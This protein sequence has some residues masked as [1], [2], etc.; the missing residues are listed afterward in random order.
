MMTK[1][2]RSA[3]AAP[4]DRKPST[5]ELTRTLIESPKAHSPENETNGGGICTSWKPLSNTF[6]SASHE[7][8]LEKLTSTKTV[9]L[10]LS[11][12][13]GPDFCHFPLRMLDDL[14]QKDPISSPEKNHE[15]DP[16]PPTTL[17]TFSV[18]MTLPARDTNFLEEPILDWQ[19]HQ[20]ERDVYHETDPPA[21]LP[22][23]TLNS[24]YGSLL[25]DFERYR[26]PYGPLR[27]GNRIS[28]SIAKRIFNKVMGL[29]RMWKTLQRKISP[30]TRG[31]GGQ[32]VK[33]LLACQVEGCDF[34]FNPYPAR[35]LT[36]TLY[37]T[38]LAESKGKYEALSYCWG[39]ESQRSSVLVNVQDSGQGHGTKEV[40]VSITRSL[41]E[42]LVDLRLTN[43]DRV[44]WA[45]A[46]CINQSD[47][48][49][50]STQ[51]RQ[52]LQVYESS[53]RTVAYLGRDMSGLQAA[54]A[55]MDYLWA[56]IDYPRV[57][58]NGLSAVWHPA[59]GLVRAPEDL[60][61]L[62][63]L[64]SEGVRTPFVTAALLPE[65]DADAMAPRNL[66]RE[67]GVLASPADIEAAW[68]KWFSLP[69]FTRAWTTQEFVGAPNVL[70]Q[71]GPGAVSFGLFD[72]RL[73][74]E[75]LQKNKAKEPASMLL[76][77]IL[78]CGGA[79]KMLQM[80]NLKDSR[81]LRIG[82]AYFRFESA[83]QYTSTPTI[84]A[85]DPRDRLWALLSLTGDRSE[86][87]LQA[88][89]D[90]D[91]KEVYGRFSRHIVSQGDLFRLLSVA[92]HTSENMP[93]WGLTNGE[94]VPGQYLSAFQ[95][96]LPRTAISEFLEGKPTKSLPVFN[97]DGTRLRVP[98]VLADRI[99]WL[100]PQL[101]DYKP[102]ALGNIF[103]T[104][105]ILDAIIQ[106][107]DEAAAAS[108]FLL[109]PE[110]PGRTL[111]DFFRGL[112][113]RCDPDSVY[114]PG[115]KA[116]YSA[117]WDGYLRA[118]LE[119]TALAIKISNQHQVD[120]LADVSSIL[121]T[122]S[123]ISMDLSALRHS[124]FFKMVQ[125][126]GWPMD[127]VQGAGRSLEPP[128]D[129]DYE[130]GSALFEKLQRFMPVIWHYFGMRVRYWTLRRVGRSRRG[131]LCNLDPRAQ[132]GDYIALMEYN[133]AT[134]LR[135]KEKGVFRIV[136]H[137]YVHRSQEGAKMDGLEAEEIWLC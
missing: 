19:G 40:A 92:P 20:Q 56:S 29:P 79:M 93:S 8:Y 126:E 28:T 53:R 106:S 74:L 75:I 25:Y 125:Q 15:L 88:D 63:Q 118:W 117:K 23:Y 91:V 10:C 129:G 30:Q 135:E 60:D 13:A 128:T 31:H 136:G 72:M 65:P 2:K 68:T 54:I 18:P 44:L 102:T 66:N 123:L 11:W 12:D 103:Q 37:A 119:S 116:A 121:S 98:A 22:H 112:T 127:M 131:Y 39:D 7:T 3:S 69:W 96:H 4:A 110:S 45:D 57:R 36:A 95:A 89:Y 90:L 70:L 49:E 24:N 38:S 84:N 85:K 132:I 27:K 50:K 42:A 80:W 16:W 46:I 55:H 64:V 114:L 52:M 104:H 130:D 107:I 94:C 9:D 109:P 35:P 99:E 115:G 61:A 48:V 71:L 51:V 76:D 1:I 67:E 122:L 6:G 58:G 78:G 124:A 77:H 100:S 87:A 33:E 120:W 34:K 21:Y 101:P 26:D 105:P 81:D 32:D 47:N 41:A 14:A 62:N 137:A 111:I 17:D 134:V 108:F 43:D 97:D 86:P 133:S 59:K 83:A 113:F 5:E 82:E 73:L